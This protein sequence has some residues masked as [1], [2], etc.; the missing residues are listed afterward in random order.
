MQI[1]PS[2][3][4]RALHLRQRC[5]HQP[6]IYR[7]TLWVAVVVSLFAVSCRLPAQA[8]TPIPPNQDIN[9]IIQELADD[10]FEIRQ[11]AEEKLIAFP[12][13]LE[14]ILKQFSNSPDN[15]LRMR[16][17]RV[18]ATRRIVKQEE[19][20]QL[21]KNGDADL[22]G[23]SFIEKALSNTK[24]SRTMYAEL[25]INHRNLLDSDDQYVS[26]EKVHLME[27]Q[28]LNSRLDPNRVGTILQ[29]EL[30]ACLAIE[31]SKSIPNHE[32]SKTERLTL[33]HKRNLF[34]SSH[35]RNTVERNPFRKL[36]EALVRNWLLVDNDNNQARDA[37]TKVEV[38]Q[39][40]WAKQGIVPAAQLLEMLHNGT[41]IAKADNIIHA[42]Q[43]LAEFGDDRHCELLQKLISHPLRVG[44]YQAVVDEEIVRNQTEV[45]DLALA[46]LI[47]LKKLPAKQFQIKPIYIRGRLAP[48]SAGFHNIE[49]RN[50]TRQ[51]WKE[52]SE[53]LN[54]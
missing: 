24:N 34:F 21:F 8:V 10:D 38:A 50:Q 49:L 14:F 19:R 47:K 18:I 23:W 54:Q 17:A 53:S 31:Y 26:A 22:P 6:S 2:T 13:Q 46:A 36:H 35:S 4:G 48:E 39:Q 29:D 12:G 15:E 43:L 45:G 11:Q 42:I 25:F 5:Q 33:T 32:I 37:A 44:A 7:V 52:Y 30:R 1:L 16:L 40:L 20:I 3:F 27:R 51:L 9:S 28:V 41:R